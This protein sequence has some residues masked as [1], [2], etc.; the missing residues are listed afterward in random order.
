MAIGIIPTIEVI[1]DGK[2]IVINE[3]DYD[4]KIHKKVKAKTVPELV[5]GE[6]DN[7]K[8]E[9]P[10]KTFIKKAVK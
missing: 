9:S 1:R 7:V 6:E 10:K 5:D 4:E 8:E 3:E 2:E